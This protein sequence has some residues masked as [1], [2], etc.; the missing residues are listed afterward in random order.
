MLL[1]TILASE[2][3]WHNRVFGLLLF[4]QNESVE[5]VTSN[6]ST[7]AVSL[8]QTTARHQLLRCNNKNS[9]GCAFSDLTWARREYG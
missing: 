4:R 7:H 1:P 3:Y 8:W 9:S 2:E 5:P 6:L